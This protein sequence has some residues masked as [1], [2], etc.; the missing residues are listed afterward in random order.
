MERS[1]AEAFTLVQRIMDA[2][3]ASDDEVANRLEGHDRDL[4]CPSG[5]V[6]DLILTGFGPLG[7]P[8]RSLRR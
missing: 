6:S 5:H 4:A 8:Q 3:Y 1:H 2:E 7:R